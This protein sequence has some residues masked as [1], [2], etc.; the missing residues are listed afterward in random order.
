[1]D[2]VLADSLPNAAWG[3][4]LDPILLVWGEGGERAVMC[5]PLSVCGPKPLM[6][7]TVPGG[8]RNGCNIYEIVM[9]SRSVVPKVGVGT[10]SLAFISHF[11]TNNPTSSIE[12][13]QGVWTF[14]K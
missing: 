9:S 10:R 7:G 5:G 8:F 13:I 6:P 3:R 11:L 4:D 12:C 2:A 14:I 1:M